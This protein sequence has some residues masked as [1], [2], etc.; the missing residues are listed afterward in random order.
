MKS[1]HLMLTILRKQEKA[2][3]KKPIK[4]I[5]EI[6]GYQKFAIFFNK[7]HSFRYKL[8]TNKLSYIIDYIMY[9]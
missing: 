1:E 6:K 5:E 7:M 3:V 9:R 4:K 8:K 2:D